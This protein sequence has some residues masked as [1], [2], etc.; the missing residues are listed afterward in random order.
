MWQSILKYFKVLTSYQ[1]RQWM[2]NLREQPEVAGNIVNDVQSILTVYFQLGE[3]PEYR[4]ALKDSKSLSYDMLRVPRSVVK[5]I[6]ADLTTAISRG[7]AGSYSQSTILCQSVSP[8]AAVANKPNKR[9]ADRL[10]ST[11]NPT[12]AT[13]QK[14][15][16]GSLSDEDKEKRKTMGIFIYNGDTKKLPPCPVFAKKDS[17]ATNEERLCT[18]FMTRGYYCNRKNCA[19]PHVANLS[20]LPEAKQREVVD[21][22][23]ATPGLEFAPGKG[24]DG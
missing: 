12:E 11:L 9:S 3:S 6:V 14:R 1:G 22:V 13:P 16:K 17:Q 7:V 10:A 20:K 2:D 23:N 21:F 5:D 4:E 18:F 15:T 19:R 24:P 8:T